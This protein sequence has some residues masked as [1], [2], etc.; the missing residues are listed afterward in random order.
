M[1]R[2]PSL[3]SN[4]LIRLED[5]LAPAVITFNLT[6]ATSS[7]AL[8]GTVSG[9][10]IAQQ[11]TGS[12]TSKY[13]GTIK[14][15]VDYAANTITFLGVDN[16]AD[17]N[18]TGNWAPLPGGASGT[19][20]ADYG[21]QIILLGA[22]VAVRDAKGRID[23]SA[24]PLIGA[25]STKS[26]TSTQ[27]F[28][29]TSGNSDYST[30]LF[31]NGTSPLAGNSG[32]NT[33]TTNGTL[34]DLGSGAYSLAVPIAVTINT[35]AGTPPNTFP[36]V[37]KINGTLNSTAT[38]PVIDLNGATA[39]FDTTFTHTAGGPPTKIAPSGTLIDGASANLTSMTVK[40]DSPPDGIAESLA[41][42][43]AGLI[44]L[45]TT[46]YD[47]GTGELKI[48]GN[49]S[50]ATY[51]SALQKVTYADSNA[52][53]TA[54]PRTVTVTVTDAG[55]SS[56]TRTALGTVIIPPAHVQS[57][58]VNDG[59]SVQR[60]QV[61]S[62][63]VTFDKHVTLPP[64]Q[65]DAFT[66]QKSDTSP[67]DLFAAV[68]DS[69]ATTV[70]T[71]TFTGGSVNGASLADGRYNL[72]VSGSQVNGG[73]FDGGS[74]LMSDYQL[75]GDPAMAP[76]LYRLFGDADG[77]NNVSSADF[78]A[79]RSVFGTMTASIFDANGDGNITSEDFSEFR[80]RFGTG[81]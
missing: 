34:N 12:L 10:A 18:V 23:S 39:G 29:L 46:G 19:A 45:S 74:G 48:S 38:I 16:S 81:V 49:A 70:V 36:V 53:G 15:D 65:T 67:V 37:L 69:G 14:A 1:R 6:M 71:L 47:S 25:G 22:L 43:L 54:G 3:L 51:Q 32:S 27:T 35:T 52:N 26:F 76:K 50:V 55:N 64:V 20:P 57:V 78:A 11:G 33:A 7:L 68:D 80:K 66:L 62:L 60:S 31:G 4:N 30:S 40:L 41:V 13:S 21:G 77:D 56:F 2:K 8:S 17:A 42:D 59:M 61:T 75:T 9:V 79:F 58:V 72:K 24:I 63:K 28:T 44:G 5:R 73:N